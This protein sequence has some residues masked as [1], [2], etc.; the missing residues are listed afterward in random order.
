MLMTPG[1]AQ[2][3]VGRLGYSLD[4]ARRV[5]QPTSLAGFSQRQG[6][7]LFEERGMAVGRG[8]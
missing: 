5:P 3:A 1:Y 8:Q 2:R 7:V 6:D 4:A